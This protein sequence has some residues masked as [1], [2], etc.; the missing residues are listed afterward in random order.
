MANE[1]PPYMLETTIG[2]ATLIGSTAGFLLQDAAVGVIALV[3]GGVSY[4]IA[5]ARPR[6]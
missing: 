1:T 5:L 2:A 4:G 3:L 6:N